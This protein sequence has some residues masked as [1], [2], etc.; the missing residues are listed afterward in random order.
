[1]GSKRMGMAISTEAGRRFCV[2]CFRKGSRYGIND[3]LVQDHDDPIIEFVDVTSADHRAPV[4]AGFIVRYPASLLLGLDREADL[5]L[6]G[7]DVAW[8]VPP[9]Q[10]R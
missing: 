8:R 5:W 9:E 10:L 7:R 3:C 4:G 1:R 2:R 6:F